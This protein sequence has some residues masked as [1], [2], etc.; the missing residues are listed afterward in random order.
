VSIDLGCVLQ[1]SR[2]T[3]AL[4]GI[5]AKGSKTGWTTHQFIAISSNHLKRST[6]TRQLLCCCYC[7]CGYFSTVRLAASR[8]RVWL[9]S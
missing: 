2:S 5:L 3:H 4:T 1:Q 9:H 8:S 7:C 6:T